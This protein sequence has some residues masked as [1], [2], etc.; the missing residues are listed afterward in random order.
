MAMRRRSVLAAVRDRKR[1]RSHAQTSEDGVQEVRSDATAPIA[2]PARPAEHDLELEQLA[3]EAR[4][5]RDRFDLYRARL[6]SGSSLPTTPSRLRELERTA[7][8]AEERLA[9]ARRGRSPR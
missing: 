5:H 4:Y 6:I 3:A 1:K 7:T 9:H 8:A 2:A